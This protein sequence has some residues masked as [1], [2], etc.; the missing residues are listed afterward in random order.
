LMKLR[1]E[2][3]RRDIAK[4]ILSI[5]HLRCLNNGGTTAVSST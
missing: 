1:A 5:F 2:N 3:L 4:I